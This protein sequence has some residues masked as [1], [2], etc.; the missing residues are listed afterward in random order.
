MS[1]IPNI[2]R[3]ETLADGS[4]RVHFTTPI[5]HFDQARSFVTFRPPSVG[6]I[7]EFGDPIEFVVQ[8]GAGTPYI[9]RKVLRRW[10]GL[11]MADHDADMIGLQRDPALGMVIEDVVLGFFTSV[12]TA[13][14]NASAASSSAA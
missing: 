3:R 8:D 14:I 12:R 13:L 2:P 1:T 9:D 6:E 4:V 7:W 10:I 11:L 5:L